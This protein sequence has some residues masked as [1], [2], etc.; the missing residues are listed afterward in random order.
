VSNSFCSRIK[1]EGHLCDPECDLLE[2]AKFLVPLFQQNCLLPWQE[3]SRDASSDAAVCDDSCRQQRT[4]VDDSQLSRTR[5]KSMENMELVK[6]TPDKVK[7][8]FKVELIFLI[9]CTEIL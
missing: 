9:V 4:K 7:F 5:R 1:Q 3:A 2:I 6:L 8:F